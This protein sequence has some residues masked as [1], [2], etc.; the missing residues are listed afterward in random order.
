MFT[1]WDL[2]DIYFFLE[3]AYNFIKCPSWK[4]AF[5]LILDTISLLPIIPSLGIIKKADKAIDLIKEKAK[6]EGLE[7]GHTEA[8]LVRS[9]IHFAKAKVKRHARFTD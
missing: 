1:V 6:A 4:T 8:E 3:S 7:I 2:L 5:N 9:A